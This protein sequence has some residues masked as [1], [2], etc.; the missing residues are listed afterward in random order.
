VGEVFTL[1]GTVT[2]GFSSALIGFVCLTQ[3]EYF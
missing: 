1:L 3:M 2:I